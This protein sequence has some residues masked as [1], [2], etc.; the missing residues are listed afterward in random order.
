MDRKH[1]LQATRKG[2]FWKQEAKWYVHFIQLVVVPQHKSIR[3]HNRYMWPHITPKSRGR[4]DLF[5]TPIQN[6][7]SILG[8]FCVFQVFRLLMGGEIYSFRKWTHLPINSFLGVL[9]T[10]LWLREAEEHPWV[11]APLSHPQVTQI[12]VCL[13]CIHRLW[14]SHIVHTL[15]FLP[16][17]CFLVHCLMCGKTLHLEVAHFLIWTWGDKGLPPLSGQWWRGL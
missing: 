16:C 11:L 6:I 15:Y 12:H 5:S 2:N 10:N 8:I 17:G 4:S 9:K 14:N 3:E 1:C 7:N 13:K